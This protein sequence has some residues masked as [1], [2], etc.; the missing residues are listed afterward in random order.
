MQGIVD[1]FRNTVDHANFKVNGTGSCHSTSTDNS[2]D[3][4]IPNPKD[5]EDSSTSC[6][7]DSDDPS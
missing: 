4:G 3:S 2:N 5:F 6:S 1:H 7:E